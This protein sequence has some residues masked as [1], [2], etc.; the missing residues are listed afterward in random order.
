M[1]VMNYLKF[2]LA[3]LLL[4][5]VLGLGFYSFDNKS[6][7][8]EWH[9]EGE[10]NPKADFEISE[11]RTLPQTRYVADTAHS[12]ILFKATHWEIVDIIGWFEDYEIVMHSD[13]K[14]F[15]DAVIE[16]RIKINSVFM[17]NKRM[18]SHIQGKEYFD[19]EKFPEVTYKSDELIQVEGNKYRLKGH[20][21]LLGKKV[22]R[23]MDA[24]YRGHAYPNEKPEHGWK[25]TTFLAHKDFGWDNSAKLHSGRLF[26]E[27]TIRIECNL[28]ME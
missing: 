4:G 6:K 5:G 18:Q 25:V 10:R 24:V 3:A 2:G 17:L 9:E 8:E 14:D 12:S 19:V 7:Q 16:A 1:Q 27:D 15:S 28:R 22:Y 11:S 23:E 20:F 26:L 13:K 21:S